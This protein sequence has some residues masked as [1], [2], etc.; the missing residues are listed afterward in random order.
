[1][2]ADAALIT[3]VDLSAF[4]IEFQVAESYAAEIKAGMAAVITLEGRDIAGL[5]TAISPRYARTRSPG[6]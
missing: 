2:A 4:E 3:V 5:V 1:M 6:G